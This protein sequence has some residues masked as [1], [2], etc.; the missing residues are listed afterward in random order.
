MW[1]RVRDKLDD[2]APYL[3][4]EALDPDFDKLEV[5]AYAAIVALVW[6]LPEPANYAILRR[7]AE[8]LE[9]Q[10]R[11]IHG[12]RDVD[13]YGDPQ[14]EILVEIQQDKLAALGLTVEQ[15]SQ[16][17][18]ASDAKVSAG[19]LRGA[20]GNLI[21]EVDTELET[22]ERVRRLPIALG[23]AGTDSGRFVALADIATISKDIVRAA[24]N[25]VACRWQASHCARCACEG[26]E[27]S[28]PLVARL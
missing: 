23:A 3:P 24:T 1:S 7:H 21:M 10:L 14:E 8:T 4:P 17:L 13:I 20:E 18:R 6:D 28:R 27:T 26:R 22:L 19:L 5:T 12:T 25:L 16:Q 11:G 15:V 2:A 9:D